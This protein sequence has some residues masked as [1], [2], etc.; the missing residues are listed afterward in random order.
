MENKKI[1]LLCLTDTAFSGLVDHFI[2]MAYGMQKEYKE[3]CFVLLSEKV[4]KVNPDVNLVSNVHTVDYHKSNLIASLKSAVH[5]VKILNKIQPN[6]IFVYGENPIHT[7]ILLFYRGRASVNLLDPKSHSGGNKLFQFLYFF[8]KLLLIVRVN[9]IYLACDNLK[10]QLYN[11]FSFFSRD[12][13]DKKIRVMDYGN[14]IQLELLEKYVDELN[15][16][17]AEKQ[18]DICYFGNMHKYKG[19]ELLLEALGKLPQP[20][21]TVIVTRQELKTEVAGISHIQCYLSMKELVEIIHSSRFVVMPYLDATG[22]HTVQ[23]AN[24][25]GAPV[26]AADTGCF[27]NFVTNGINGIK[28]VAGDCNALLAVLTD[29]NKFT[30]E[31]EA[32]RQYNREYFSMEKSALKLYAD[33]NS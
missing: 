30:F 17:A 23:I 22:T 24:F 16:A 15:S 12:Y 6:H 25:C 33:L 32:I 26:I 1:V 4:Q 18:F 31:R 28:F 5:A 9:Y 27:T 13:F 3:N 2:S 8:S 10:Y 11:S 7:L 14:F 19:V 21:R 20:L 29:L